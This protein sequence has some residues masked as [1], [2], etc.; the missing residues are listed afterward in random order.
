VK[1]PL[2]TPSW[3]YLNI[4]VLMLVDDDKYLANVMQS[5]AQNSWP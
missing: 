2:S 3:K 5:I 4:S 1:Q